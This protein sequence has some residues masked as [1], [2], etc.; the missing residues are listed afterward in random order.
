[1]RSIAI[2]SMLL[3]GSVHAAE[4]D[5]AAEAAVERQL[6]N[7]LKL[8]GLAFHN[9]HDIFNRFPPAEVPGPD[10]E[11]TP[12]LR[13][14]GQQIRLNGAPETWRKQWDAWIEADG[15]RLRDR[16][17]NE[18]NLAFLKRIPDALRHPRDIADSTSTGFVVVTG[19]GSAFSKDRF[20][21]GI[22][23]Q[24]IKDGTSN[25]LLVA[26]AKCGIPW[27]AT[28]D[29]E[30]DAKRPFPK[31]GGF[32]PPQT[33]ILTCDGAVHRLQPD[34]RDPD[35]RALTTVAGRDTFA[36]PGIPWTARRP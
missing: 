2:L 30:L 33:F 23:Q 27:T 18:S 6:K 7:N 13:P 12:L 26:E 31:L 32:G 35:L 21:K 20:P 19:D 14:Q 34:V 8:L 28:D 24:D 15:Y 3:A 22:A 1:M 25:T 11:I 17:D 16:W 36:I 10:P 29:L 5:P 4:P 9:Y